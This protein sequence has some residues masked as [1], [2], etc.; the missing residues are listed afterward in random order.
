MSDPSEE[1]R[2][3][4]TIFQIGTESP[5]SLRAIWPKGNVSARAA[6]NDTFTASE[7]PEL[8]DRQ[9]AFENSALRLNGQGYN[10]YIVMNP[11]RPDFT[12]ETVTDADIASRNL[13]LIDLDRAGE[14]DAPAT[15]DEVTAAKELGDRIA[16]YLAGKGW[17][18]P[19]R[20]MSGNGHHL[21]YP[22]DCFANDGE[23]R[24]YVQTLLQQ[25]AAEFDGPLIRVDTSVFNASRIT[26][27]PGTIAR[28]G[29][30]SE[31]RPHRIARVL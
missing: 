4:W 23:S 27:V 30:E 15:D 6:V 28:K 8:A 9:H 10:V 5:I 21:Y 18:T 12:G 11:I 25:L 17:V 13:V 29:K 22:L 24:D 7:F 3:M 20:M 2:R 31:G 16:D 26:K 1:I 19:F 14:T